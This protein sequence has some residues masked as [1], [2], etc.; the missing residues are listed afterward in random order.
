[1]L[2]VE[3]D[4]QDPRIFALRWG[5]AMLDEHSAGEPQQVVRMMGDIG[6]DNAGLVPPLIDPVLAGLITRAALAKGKGD[7]HR[8]PPARARRGDISSCVSSQSSTTE[9]R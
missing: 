1:M 8:R 6:H 2:G 5:F 4:Q 3:H 9:R 7:T